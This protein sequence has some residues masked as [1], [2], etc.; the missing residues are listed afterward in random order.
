MLRGDAGQRIPLPDGMYL[1]GLRHDDRL[2]GREPIR[3]VQ[4]VL[5]DQQLERRMVGLRD[6]IQGIPR[7][8]NMDHHRKTTFLPS[9]C[10]TPSVRDRLQ[11][12][13]SRPAHCAGR[14]KEIGY[15]FCSSGGVSV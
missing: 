8:N 15:R 5:L 7:L 12:R 1:H 6:A 11:A 14:L 4:L 13:K 9:L 10:R 3:L 2:P